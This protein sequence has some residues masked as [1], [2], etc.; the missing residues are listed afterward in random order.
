MLLLLTLRSTDVFPSTT[1]CETSSHLPRLS[2]PECEILIPSLRHFAIALQ[3]AGAR[4]QSRSL[5]FRRFLYL[6]GRLDSCLAMN[7]PSLLVHPNPRPD[8]GSNGSDRT[9]RVKNIHH[10]APKFTHA[11]QAV[12]VVA[13][14]IPV[15]R[16]S[17]PIKA[18]ARPTRRLFIDNP[19]VQWSP[20]SAAR[21]IDDPCSS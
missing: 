21:Q 1:A 4:D 7:V 14:A 3:T 8:L 19:Q 15:N 2:R 5:H 16:M 18:R 9:T 13:T 17:G 6:G 11:A 20:L 10:Q 12:Y